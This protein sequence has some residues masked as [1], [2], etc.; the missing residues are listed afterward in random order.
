MLPHAGIRVQGCIPSP[1]TEGKLHLCG[2]M[3]AVYLWSCNLCLHCI[4]TGLGAHLSYTVTYRNAV[5][6]TQMHAVGRNS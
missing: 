3:H 4:T 5:N 2:S 1:V 6:R